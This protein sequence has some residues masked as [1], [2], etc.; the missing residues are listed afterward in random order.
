MVWARCMVS[1]IANSCLGA[2][3]CYRFAPNSTS[4]VPLNY[5]RADAD[6]WSYGCVA[7]ELATWIVRGPEGLRAYR[8]GRIDAHGETWVDKDC[9]HNG[10]ESL[11]WITTFHERLIDQMDSDPCNAT[12]SALQLIDKYMLQFEPTKRKHPSR[13]MH[14]A[15]SMMRE[16][17][18]NILGSGDM[19]P[20]SLHSSVSTASDSLLSNVSGLNISHNG[21]AQAD[22][23][24]E[25]NP[26]PPPAQV[27]PPP[28]LTYSR[29]HLPQ[30][31]HSSATNHRDDIMAGKNHGRNDSAV[32]SPAPR[33]RTA[34]VP[35]P[36]YT[37]DTDAGQPH[38]R[39][40]QKPDDSPRD[41]RKR[42]SAG[43]SV[44][45]KSDDPVNS[46]SSLGLASH[47]QTPPMQGKRTK[48]P[49]LS[50]DKALVWSLK[51]KNEGWLSS[52]VLH[53]QEK[54]HEHYWR[55]LVRD[56][57]NRDFVSRHIGMLMSKLT[58]SIANNR[59]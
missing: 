26:S 39:G 5:V 41:Q 7:S 21:A 9:F 48:V 3:E 17:A 8:E 22:R 29:D 15:D 40:G 52:K 59:R 2:P 27:S 4:M 57:S 55:Q 32:Q 23:F 20:A 33:Q 53:L 28:D 42:F 31:N 49:F 36:N 10:Y 14:E 34:P 58:S 46:R 35:M 16:V 1:S 6:L 45:F 25:T 44:L 13:L 11:P 38:L 56:L 12:V 19:P 30:Q 37:Q 24:C 47:P 54:A 43:L 50:V 51:T 18:R